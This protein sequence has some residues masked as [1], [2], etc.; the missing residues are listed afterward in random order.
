MAKK[1]FDVET[2]KVESIDI[3]TPKKA[4]NIH[5]PAGNSKQ[6]ENFRAFYPLDPN[7]TLANELKHSQDKTLKLSIES[8]IGSGLVLSMVDGTIGKGLQLETSI[9]SK[10]I[11]VNTK[12]ISSTSQMIE[13]LWD[14]WSKTPEACDFYGKSSFGELCRIAATNAYNTGD[15]LQFIGIRKW[16]DVFVPYVR[17]YDGRSVQND[18]K[19]QD[20]NKCTAGVH[21]DDQGRETGYTIA[22]QKGTYEEVYKKVDREVDGINGT[23]RVQYNLICNGRIQ[24]NQRRGRAL[25]L[26][27]IENMILLNRF[28]EA[29]VVKAMIQSYIT[30]YI[31]VDKDMAKQGGFQGDD[32]LLGTP[33]EQPADESGENDSPITF[34]PGYIHRLNPGE[35][36]NLPESKSPVPQF[37]SF[38]EGQLKIICMGMRIPYEVALQVFNSNYSASQASIQAAA[39]RWE[40]ERQTLT[41][42][43]VRNV[44]N[45]FLDLMVAQGFVSCPGYT[46]NPFVKAAWRDAN[47]HGPVILNIDPVKNAK[48]ASL[49]IANHTSTYQDEC[50]AQ[51][52]D[53]DKVVAQRASEEALLKSLGLKPDLSGKDKPEEVEEP[54]EKN[55]NQKGE[56]E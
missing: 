35:T 45:L 28:N 13:D 41:T 2:N 20:T 38:M 44:Y 30:G 23:K 19:Q 26:P 42:E 17:F 25:I 55:S 21:I 50:R 11:T 43:M 36:F 18:Q 40:I 5:S 32:P 7:F 37:W 24:P 34:G 33:T 48:S 3:A 53:F 15:V 4:E 9:T 8:P 12:K 6:S 52:K 47:W 46:K 27:S 56:K 10:L 49:R 54:E 1:T 16:G 14:L 22:I 39:R 31:E 51:G 29:E